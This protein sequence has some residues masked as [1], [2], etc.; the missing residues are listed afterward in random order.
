MK[1]SLVCAIATA[2]VAVLGAV[3]SAVSTVVTRNEKQEWEA[4]QI[5]KS[6]VKYMES[7]SLGTNSEV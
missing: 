5:D 2:G 7:H 3:L 4:E 6:V 1:K